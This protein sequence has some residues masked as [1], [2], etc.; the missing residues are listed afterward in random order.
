MKKQG[1]W[2]ETK[3]KTPICA[4]RGELLERERDSFGILYTGY[5]LSIV[6]IKRGRERQRERERETERERERERERKKERERA[7]NNR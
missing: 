5:L 4:L 6:K 1:K 2:I 3:T 7:T